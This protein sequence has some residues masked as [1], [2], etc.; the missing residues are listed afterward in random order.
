MRIRELFAADITRDI[1]P[2][3]YF[4]EQSPEKLAAEVG[5]YIVTGGYPDGDPRAARN[6]AGIHEELVR[7]L[8]SLARELDKKG[9]PELPAVWISGFFGSGKSSF[10]KLLGLSLDGI[11]LAGGISMSEAFLARDSSPRS[12]ELREAW[13]KLLSKIDAMAVVFDIGSVVRDGEQIHTAAR[14][15][16]QQRLGYCPTSAIVADYEARLEADGL[17]ERFLAAAE[18]TLGR[19]WSEAKGD[20]LADDHFSHVLH[21]LDPERYAE[22]TTWIDSRGGVSSSA[23]SSVEETTKAIEAM[24]DRRAPGKTLFLVLDEVSQY[25]HQDENRMLKLQSFVADLGHRLKGRVWILATGQQKLEDE[26]AANPLAKLK[27]RFPP[28]LRVHLATSN[29]RDVVHQRLLRKSP[30]REGIIRDRFRRDRSDLKLYAYDCEEVTE[31]DFV[32]VYPMLPGHVDLLL[33]ITSSL[34]SRSTRAQGDDHAIRGLLQLLGEL[35]RSQKLAGA[36]FGALVTLDAIY[37]VQQSALDPDVQMTLGRLFQDEV[38]RKE[39]LAVRAAKAVALLELIQDEVPTTVELVAQG[40]YAIVGQGNSSE[41]V[42]KALEALREHGFLGYSEKSGYKIQSSA[43]GEWQR[44]R[45]EIGVPGEKVNEVVRG[46]LTELLGD[47]DRGR[48]QGRSFPWGALFSDGRAIRDARILDTRDEAAVTVDFRFLTSKD[49]RLPSKWVVESAASDLKDRL[50]WVA[51]EPGPVADL[52][53]DLVRARHMAERYEARRA[54]LPVARQRLLLEE[55]TR[56][57]ELELKVRKAVST[58]FLE[59]KFYF[60]GRALAPA[61]LGAG[62]AGALQGAADRILPDLF[63]RFVPLAVTEAELAQLL[64]PVLAGPS[65]KFLEKGLGILSLDAGKYAADCSGEVPQ[66][67]RQL[68]ESEGGASGATLFQHF[69]RPPFG[70]P[71]DVIRA[72]VA[73]L[74]RGHKVRI[75]PESGPEI[76]SI[77]DPGTKDLF[78]RDRDLRRADVLPAKEGEVGPRDRVAIC[79]LFKERL[80]LE[81]DREDEAIADAVY[82]H[83]PSRLTQLG[84]IRTRLLR[85]SPQ[86]K[87][88]DLAQVDRLERALNECRRSRQVG[89]T[90]TA[91]KRHLDDLRDGLELLGI[92]RSDLTEDAIHLLEET[93]RVSDSQLA[94]LRTAGLLGEAEPDAGAVDEQL[95]RERPWREAGT[96]SGALDGIRK[97]YLV[98]RRRLQ[99]EQEA[100]AEEARARLTARDGFARLTPDQAHQVLLPLRKALYDTTPDQTTPTLVEL[101]DGFGPRLQ[102]AE[103]EANEQLDR[104]LSRAKVGPVSVVRVEA[105]LHGRE[106]KNREELKALL[107]ELEERIGPA[108]DRG[109]RV[110]I[111]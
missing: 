34:R 64:E 19:P 91:V 26:A 21:V 70:W 39:P 101:R 8:T 7:L 52:A 6:R 20:K 83:F 47:V 73:G 103:E 10:A 11:P 16:I 90:V 68:V 53:R 60:A 110:R 9:G 59:G 13:T 42:G 71:A 93:R 40:L 44:E 94:Q 75:R 109:E 23:G 111:V 18:K 99:A 1:P 5:E 51:G 54:S 88:A 24:L 56:R 82:S 41:A 87:T 3:V 72:A 86:G 85:L 105:R 106:V 55:Q 50:I 46:K 69:G 89:E 67:I 49:D 107:A 102:R 37:E 32:E 74:L 62:F 14:R 36:E 96:V 92:L 98:I 30:D 29:I 65:T 97:Q 35:F 33:R 79:Q 12:G 81:L 95:R 28:S 100:R 104:E 77:K 48:L 4:H 43:G 57:D 38:A 27:D 25:V 63:P 22:P 31:E 61:D 66:K 58:A 108:L 15:Q 84:E 2:V 80:G 17:W 45:D 78:R 76:T